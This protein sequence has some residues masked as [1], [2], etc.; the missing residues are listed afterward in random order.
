[1]A[2]P[3]FVKGLRTLVPVQNCCRNRDFTRKER[4]IK[5]EGHPRMGGVQSAAPSARL[6]S[7]KKGMSASARLPLLDGQAKQNA[8]GQADGI[9]GQDGRMPKTDG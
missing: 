9:G 4:E 3:I 6:P 7:P 2:T 1:M 5:N 8:G